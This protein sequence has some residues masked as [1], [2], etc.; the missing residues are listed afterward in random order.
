MKF[1][2]SFLY[3]FALLFAM[4][5]VQAQDCTPAGVDTDIDAQGS[6]GTIDF[7]ASDS[8]AIHWDTC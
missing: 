7:A 8:S 4:A 6:D 2:S 5:T 1:T 3:A